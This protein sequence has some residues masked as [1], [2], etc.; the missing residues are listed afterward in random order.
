TY[1]ERLNRILRSNK[2]SDAGWL[3]RE[4]VSKEILTRR[5]YELKGKQSEPSPVTLPWT[6]Q[7]P[8]LV[9]NP[10]NPTATSPNDSRRLDRHEIL[11]L[12][13]ENAFL[14]S[15]RIFAP[16]SA[17]DLTTI[18]KNEKEQTE[19]IEQANKGSSASQLGKKLW[20]LREQLNK[21][22]DNLLR[23]D[24]NTTDKIDETTIIGGVDPG[25]SYAL[26]A[27]FFAPRN[28]TDK[29][30]LAVK[31]R[32]SSIAAFDREEQQL[33]VI[34][35]QQCHLRR[36]IKVL[37]RDY[38]SHPEAQQLLARL[39]RLCEREA[40]QA[41]LA[42]RQREK[43]KADK[44]SLAARIALEV[45][46][47]F[48]SP[49]GVAKKVLLFVGEK[50]KGPRAK[51][52]SGADRRWTLVVALLRALNALDNVT[53]VAYAVNEANTTKSC[54]N[55][56][57]RQ[58]REGTNTP[59]KMEHPKRIESGRSHLRLLQCAYCRRRYH[60]DISA[61]CSI[62]QVG[63]V[64][65]LMRKT[66]LFGTST[67]SILKRAFRLKATSNSKKKAKV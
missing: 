33:Q 4:A 51:P 6:T 28:A 50:P 36:I 20:P 13:Y 32:S 63:I 29:D 45:T 10:S 2:T 52:A 38:D 55:P 65:F 21:E 15:R 58:S 56:V 24:I 17:G 7:G 37:Q 61:A 43:G 44:Q 40:L 22:R 25:Q 57:C 14:D 62:A 47:A 42:Y 16:I 30:A 1:I 3:E 66:W 27:M 49:E 35:Q 53:A 59:E 54:P 64:Q 8:Y 23:E 12:N 18:E 19:E 41:Q 9:Y 34:W 67:A 60:R 31:V 5:F 39:K 46:E 11:P 48:K 26:A